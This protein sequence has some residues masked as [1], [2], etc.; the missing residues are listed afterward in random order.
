[1][2]ADSDKH[3][4]NDDVITQASVEQTGT[5][6]EQ[7]EVDTLTET[8]PVHS[9]STSSDRSHQP[10]YVDQDALQSGSI[11]ELAK[12]WLN[13]AKL[14][15]KKLML[16]GKITAAIVAVIVVV[17][18]VLVL[19]SVFS[20]DTNQTEH[21]DAKSDQQQASIRQM[22]KLP[23][24]FWL[25]LEGEILIVR[26]LG[27]SGDKQ[28]LW[29]LA[30]AIGDKTCANLEFNDG[31]RYRP[32]TVDLL[33]D[34]ASEARFTPLDKDAIVNHVALRGSFKLCGYEF[35]LKGSQATLMQN[36]QFE[37]IISQ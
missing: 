30:T 15:Q 25:A 6:M 18:L 4:L 36:P 29:R 37:M 2:S 16:I 21:V 9:F 19:I 13:V 20:D 17:Y 27:E 23:D 7:E 32:I 22:I 34:G 1:Y 35:S 33:H 31:S 10:L 5:N 28:N 8:D 26:W 24:G 3:S 12:S 14:H 11:T